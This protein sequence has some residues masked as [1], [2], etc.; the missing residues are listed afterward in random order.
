LAAFNE[1]I[2]SVACGIYPPRRQKAMAAIGLFEVPSP[3]TIGKLWRV[4]QTQED[5]V[6]KSE[7]WTFTNRAE[8]IAQLKQREWK[9]YFSEA[10]DK[11]NLG[12]LSA[13]YRSVSKSTFRAFRTHKEWSP[14]FVFREWAARNL[15]RGGLSELLAVRSN[16]QY[17][18]W[19]VSLARSLSKEWQKH[20]RYEL[21]L[22]RALKLVNLLAKGLCLVPP[23]W[24]DKLDVIVPSIEIPL[25]KYSL[26]PLACIP[27]LGSLGINW[28]NA[29]MGSIEDL[30]TYAKIQESIRAF[31]AEANVP[32]L[33]YDF[34]AW[35]APHG[36]RWNNP[37]VTANKP[38]KSTR[39]EN[40]ELLW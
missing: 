36:K 34:L 28:N 35:D 37:D 38:P 18:S 1:A 32:P 9:N 5:Y 6:P 25:D 16:A 23:V 10:Y 27:E 39:T 29:S 19:A 7:T 14:S 31:C 4:S 30:K 8:L 11:D 3:S 26:R 21:D 24:P 12:P 20:L 13:I 40:W 33:A 22:P 15:E 2:N 17:R